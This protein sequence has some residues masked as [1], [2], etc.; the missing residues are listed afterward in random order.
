MSFRDAATNRIEPR[1]HL[2]ALVV[3]AQT[4]V[5]DHEHFLCDVLEV[6]IAD[7]EVT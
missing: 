7:A 2:V 5:H 4:V 3:A 1:T 6:G